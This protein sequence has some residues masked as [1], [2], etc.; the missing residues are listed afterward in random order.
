MTVVALRLRG[1]AIGWQP[2]PPPMDLAQ[3]A[4]KLNALKV[5]KA[6]ANPEN[7]NL[8]IGGSPSCRAL[9][10]AYRVMPEA[11]GSLFT[12]SEIIVVSC[13]TPWLSSAYL[14]MSL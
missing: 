12:L 9:A 14:E 7:I 5:A 6:T 4:E 2:L 11:P 3:V 1:Q 13:I 10:R 8:A